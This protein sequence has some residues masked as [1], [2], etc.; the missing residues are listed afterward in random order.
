MSVNLARSP[1]SDSLCSRRIPCLPGPITNSPEKQHSI[2]FLSFG[3]SSWSLCSL[4][5]L[6]SAT[7]SLILQA[8]IVHETSVLIL[9]ELFTEPQTF[10]FCQFFFK[11]FNKFLSDIPSKHHRP[12][13]KC[14]RPRSC[15]KKNV[16]HKHACT[17]THTHAHACTHTRTH[18]HYF[19]YRT[20]DILYLPPNKNPDPFV[21]PFI[22]FFSA[23]DLAFQTDGR[24][25]PLMYMRLSLGP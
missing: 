9:T 21:F 13:H 19:H 5:C 25:M 17:H 1:H 8:S 4:S 12:I 6:H 2:Y 23:R 7:F 18:R 16:S 22:P 14:Y 15:R 24:K 20:L 3:P 10:T 11:N